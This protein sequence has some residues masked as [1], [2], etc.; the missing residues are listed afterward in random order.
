LKITSSRSTKRRHLADHEKM[1]RHSTP[2]TMNFVEFVPAE[3]KELNELKELNERKVKE[4]AKMLRIERERKNEEM[5]KAHRK[6]EKF[7]KKLF[8]QELETGGPISE[9]TP[10]RLLHSEIHLD[11]TRTSLILPI[12]NIV[13]HFLVGDKRQARDIE[14]RES[15]FNGDVEM[16]RLF[17]QLE[18]LTSKNSKEKCCADLLICS[19]VTDLVLLKVKYCPVWYKSNPYW[20]NFYPIYGDKITLWL[21]D[22]NLW[23]YW[24]GISASPRAEIHLL[25]FASIYQHFQNIYFSHYTFIGEKVMYH[26]KDVLSIVSCNTMSTTLSTT[27]QGF[28]LTHL[29]GF[30]DHLNLWKLERRPE[31]KCQEVGD[32]T[33][34][35]ISNKENIVVGKKMDIIIGHIQYNLRRMIVDMD[36]STDESINNFEK[37]TKDFFKLMKQFKINPHRLFF[38]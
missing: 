29:L 24:N 7:D 20:I 38:V 1:F 34:Y 4:E 13:E 18:S 32:E 11:L 3:Q 36:K 10:S 16:L 35:F 23:F 6:Q 19:I 12:V 5:K 21:K 2:L 37:I 25:D 9:T 33:F 8:R 14:L 26:H 17:Q 15:G 31:Y 30:G 22:F 27:F 28:D